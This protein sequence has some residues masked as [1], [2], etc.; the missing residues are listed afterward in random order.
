M[1]SISAELSAHLASGNTTMVTCWE[2]SRKDGTV[3][4]FT[5]HVA[6]LYVSSITASTL[7]QYEAATGYTPTALKQNALLSV[8]NL[9]VTGL[10]DSAGITAADIEAKKYDDADVYIFMVNY[11]DLTMGKLKMSR[12]RIGNIQLK[13]NTYIAEFRSLTQLLQQNIGERYSLRCRAILGDSRCK[14]PISASAWTSTTAYSS[15]DY[16]EPSTYNGYIFKCTT[17]GSTG[18]SE[19]SWPT[20]ETSVAE[21]SIVWVG[22]SSWKRQA[23]SVTSVSSRSEFTAV[24][25][26]HAS[27]WFDYGLLSWTNASS[28]NDGYDMEVKSFASGGRIV[29]AEPMPYNISP[30]DVFE[31]SPGCGKRFAEDCRDKFNNVPNFRGEPYIPGVDQINKFG[32]Q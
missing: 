20:S 21:T 26:A 28:D 27:A 32:G 10:L 12:G 22:V 18:A 8:D 30:A 3:L 11:D 25:L 24:E 1:K 16:V 13:D 14:I 29:L 4:G 19:P 5:D 17:P 23:V 6:D 7:L 31:I 9:D 15:G 2:I